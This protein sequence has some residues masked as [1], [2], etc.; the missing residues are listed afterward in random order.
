[1]RYSTKQNTRVDGESVVFMQRGGGKALG[2]SGSVRSRRLV[3]LLCTA[4]GAHARTLASNASTHLVQAVAGASLLF[5]SGRT[6]PHR[7]AAPR[8]PAPAP[9]RWR[10][11]C[12]S[13]GGEAAAGGWVGERAGQ[14]EACPIDAALVKRYR[15]SP[16]VALTLAYGPCRPPAMPSCLPAFSAPACPAAAS[17]VVHAVAAP[18]GVPHNL[19]VDAPGSAE[20]GVA[21][22]HCKVAG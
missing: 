14:E 2:P 19:A 7:T 18:G 16:G 6:H 11:S 21:H 1:M 22:A 9:D 17:Q 8:R 5:R 13:K 15:C 20:A 12:G 10:S 4:S 3:R